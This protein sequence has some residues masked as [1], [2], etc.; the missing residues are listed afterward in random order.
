MR[1]IKLGESFVRVS[2]SKSQR[3]E[4]GERGERVDKGEK[5]ERGEKDEGDAAKEREKPECEI[6]RDIVSYDNYMF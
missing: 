3:T 2:L 4:G 1:G 6:G 5:G